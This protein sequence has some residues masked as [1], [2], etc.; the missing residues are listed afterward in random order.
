MCSTAIPLIPTVSARPVV[1]IE[2]VH[3]LRTRSLHSSPS[4]QGVLTVQRGI[5]TLPVTV[6]PSDTE[7]RAPLSA[8][9][10][11]TLPKADLAIPNS[12]SMSPNLHLESQHV[13]TAQQI[14]SSSSTQSVVFDQQS[15]RNPKVSVAVHSPLA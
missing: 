2:R 13:E 9:F 7:I 12:V 10:L 8:V 11:Q 15:V 14:S 5:P 1:A 4:L 6:D 3:R